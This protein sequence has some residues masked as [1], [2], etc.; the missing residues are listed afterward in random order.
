M[1]VV[2]FG[3]PRID[4]TFSDAGLTISG[5]CRYLEETENGYRCKFPL[6]IRS[7]NEKEE[8]ERRHIRFPTLLYCQWPIE[9]LCIRR[10]DEK[11][12]TSS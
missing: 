2:T 7:L 10:Y 4:L 12:P 3:P 6:S 5:R 9:D 11:L 8:D 1:A